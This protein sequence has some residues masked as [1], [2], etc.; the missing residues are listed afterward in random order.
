MIFDCSLKHKCHYFSE[1]KLNL[2]ILN[3]LFLEEIWF[4]KKVQNSCIFYF[5]P[6]LRKPNRNKMASHPISLTPD[7]WAVLYNFCGCSLFFLPKNVVLR[8][9]KGLHLSGLSVYLLALIN[10]MAPAGILL[11]WKCYILW[12]CLAKPCLIRQIIL[13]SIR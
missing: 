13:K 2:F 10:F 6:G 1:V 7:I 9:L 3:N 8:Y 4:R 5:Y 12:P 11:I